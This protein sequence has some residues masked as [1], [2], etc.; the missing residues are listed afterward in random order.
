MIFPVQ[1]FKDLAKISPT[2]IFDFRETKK[3]KLVVGAV[4]SSNVLACCVEYKVYF[5]EQDSICRYKIAPLDKLMSPT[6]NCV[7]GKSLMF[8]AGGMS[9]YKMQ[10]TDSISNLPIG[11]DKSTHTI[12]EFSLNEIYGITELI[13]PV[14]SCMFMETKN[15]MLKITDSDIKEHVTKSIS[16]A[17]SSREKVCVDPDILLKVLDIVPKH[18]DM[19]VTLGIKTGG[20]ITVSYD[21]YTFYIA[22]KELKG[23]DIDVED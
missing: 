20:P 22:P 23:I 11:L 6:V 15:K 10:D 7:V 16:L 17:K 5:D 4:D 2:M 21:N 12:M 8:R 1:L 19:T 13:A 3:G 18:R 9:I 14:S